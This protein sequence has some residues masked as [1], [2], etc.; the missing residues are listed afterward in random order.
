MLARFFPSQAPAG[1][2]A[3]QVKPPHAARFCH[4]K[5]NIHISQRRTWLTQG[6]ARANGSRVS[7]V[8]KSQPDFL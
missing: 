2:A 7:H 4:G 5:S 3:K 6:H 1:N 8:K